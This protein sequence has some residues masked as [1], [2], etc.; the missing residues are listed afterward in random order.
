MIDRTEISKLY[1]EVGALG[2]AFIITI[3]I[4]IALFR[5]FLSSLRNYNKLIEKMLV[6]KNKKNQ[7]LYEDMIDK[8]T[9][10]VPSEE[11]NEKLSKLQI[12]IDKELKSILAD[13]SDSKLE[14]RIKELE[15]Q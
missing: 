3:L 9:M 13:V 14:E 11:E 12:V 10:H 7:E 4:L 2:V 8:I 6:V 1:L 15:N 5:Y